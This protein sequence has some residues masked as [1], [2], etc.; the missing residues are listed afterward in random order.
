M[1]AA[2]LNVSLPTIWRWRKAGKF[3]DPVNLPGNP[4]WRRST[5]EKL[6]GVPHEQ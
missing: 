5:I 4:R 3:P 1:V 6:K 2:E